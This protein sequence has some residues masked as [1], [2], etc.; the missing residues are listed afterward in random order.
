MEG[1]IAPI[2]NHTNQRKRKLGDGLFTEEADEDDAAPHDVDTYLDKLHT[3]LLAYAIAG[4]AQMPSAPPVAEEATM[5]AD[6]TLFVVA[7]LDILLAYHLRAKR[8]C[9]QIP[10]GRRLAW[11]TARDADERAEWVSRFRESTLSF[12]QVVKQVFA[13]RDAHWIPAA[14]TMPADIQPSAINP[15]PGPPKGQIQPGSGSQFSLGKPIN[16]RKVAKVMKDGTRLC[17]AFQHAQ[18]KAK[19]SCANGAHGCGLVL[20]GERVCGAP[21]HGAPSLDG[22]RRGLGQTLHGNPNPPHYWL[23]SFVGRRHPSPRLSSF[24][25]GIASQ[26]IGSS[27]HR[28]SHDLSNPLRQQSLSEQLQDADCIMAAFDSALWIGKVFKVSC[29]FLCFFSL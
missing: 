7:P 1:Q 8:T 14:S 19:G 17:A 2:P 20:R 28:P 6:T 21:S 5:G 29:I 10:A 22:A 24:V 18:R 13:A 9:A 27:T 11:L 15:T 12:G 25:D 26:S 23:T 16:S 4:S 3:L